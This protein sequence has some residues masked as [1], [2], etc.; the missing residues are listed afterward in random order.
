ML[1]HSS[2]TASAGR[3]LNQKDSCKKCKNEFEKFVLLG[4]YKTASPAGRP[5]AEAACG[6]LLLGSTGLGTLGSVF[7]A[8]LG[9]I[10]DTCGI[11]SATDDVITHTGKVLYTT[12]AYEHD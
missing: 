8:A 10:L 12:A 11:E 4:C 7:G 5:T 3:L 1:R 9:T 6:E 2:A